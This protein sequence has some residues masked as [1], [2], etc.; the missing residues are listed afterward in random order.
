MDNLNLEIYK[1]EVLGLVGESGCG[2][3]VL[4]HAILRLTDPNEIIRSGK[5]LFEGRD[6]FSF[7]EKELREYRWRDVAIVFQGALN[8]LNPILKVEDHMYDTVLAH[9]RADEEEIW[10]RAAS[11]LE[12]L[13]LDGKLV[14]P[15]YPHEL[16]GGMKQR[17]VSALAMLLKPKLLILDE[18][19][20]SLDMLTQ[21]YMVR[22]LAEIKEKTDITMLFITHDLAVEAEIA[23]RIAVMYSGDIVEIGKINEV[24]YD[25]IHPYTKALIRSVP[26]LVGDVSKFKP[27]PGPLPDPVN[28][29]PGCRFHPR[30]PYRKDICSKIRPKHEKLENGRVI[31]CHRWREINE[32]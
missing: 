30:C 23:D 3:S 15:R 28:L 1:G 17:V 21:K 12:T 10:R 4:A 13:R 24:F 18:P 20:S 19:T 32:E 16:S 7:S 25:P 27:I 22:M 2:K 6:V 31:A 5:I 14:L 26:S 29:P 11:L 8:S 9:E